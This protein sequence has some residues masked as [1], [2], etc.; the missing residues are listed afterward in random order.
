MPTVLGLERTGVLLK[1]Y[2]ERETDSH[3]TEYK[4][5]R[6]S[7][8]ISPEYT[9]RCLHKLNI[10][11]PDLLANMVS[12]FSWYPFVRGRCCSPLLLK[13]NRVYFAYHTTHRANRHTTGVNLLLGIP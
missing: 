3:E 10:H 4:G 7:I 8:S 2:Y 6:P 11:T 1:E 12:L 5:Q 9:P 13:Q